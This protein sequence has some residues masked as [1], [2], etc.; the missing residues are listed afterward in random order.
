MT[1]LK[2]YADPV[3]HAQLALVLE[4]PA[5]L[6]VEGTGASADFTGLR[7]SFA[8]LLEET[9]EGAERSFWDARLVEPLHRALDIS[10][11]LAADMRLWHWLCISELREIVWERWHGRVPDNIGEAL[12]ESL[13]GRFLG[14]ATLN[15]VSRNALARLW[16][17]GETLKTGDATDPYA[18]ARK[19][20]E[21]QDLFQAIFEREFGLYPP[22]A[23]ACLK[24]YRDASP[25]QFRKGTRMLNH[26]LTTIALESLTESDILAILQ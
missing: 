15:G 17:C 21:R 1:I 23:R 10:H 14:T 13:A 18:L 6:P 5:F 24:R 22:A 11:R 25:R 12:S 4:R 2:R 8:R 16:W 7:E 26:S 3:R 19:A 20:L 9:P